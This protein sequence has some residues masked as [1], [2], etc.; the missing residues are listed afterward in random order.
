MKNIASCIKTRIALS[1]LMLM[2]ML[3]ASA[4]YKMVVHTNNGTSTEFWASSVDSVTWEYS[5]PVTYEYVDLGLSVK[6][7]TMNVGATKPEGYGDYFAWGETEPRTE[8]GWSTYKYCNGSDYTMTKYCN[9][10]DYGYNSYT[11]SKTVLD[12][13]DDAATVSLGGNWRLPTKIEMDELKGKC[14]WTWTTLNGVNGYKVQSK[15]SGYKDNWIFLPAAGYMENS[16]VTDSGS[17]GYYWSR[18]LHPDNMNESYYMDFDKQKI[19][20]YNGARYYGHTVRPVWDESNIQVSSVSLDTTQLSLAISETYRLKGTVYPLNARDKDIVWSSNDPNVASVDRYGV[21]TANSF[22]ECTI[23]AM[24]SNEVFASCQVTV[25]A[26]DQSVHEYVD[27]GLSVKWATMNVGASSMEDYGDYFAWGET[28]GYLSGKEN[29]T[30]ETYKFY[31]YYG[32]IG[33]GKDEDGFDIP[34]TDVWGYTKYVEAEDSTGTGFYDNRCV[35]D[36]LDDAAYV[37]WGG[38][39]RMPT[40]AEWQELLDKCTWTWA[41]R[42]DINGFKVTGPNG[43]WIFLPAA[44][45]RTTYFDDYYGNV[46]FYWSSTLRNSYPRGFI[47]NNFV[48]GAERSMGLSIRPVCP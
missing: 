22:G 13:L 3:T 35:L 40:E 25:R 44:G 9:D 47:D 34:V 11:D 1:V 31:S 26:S 21:V 45:N 7:A 42:N 19:Q 37:N 28:K 15:I 2:A 12:A 17:F 39:W 43:N 6:W 8:Y 27:L 36:P 30:S 29:F 20:T 5:E 33:G 16:K 23:T 4:Q 14:T 32:T 18:S 48:G 41:S 46:C 24:T 38:D 10:S